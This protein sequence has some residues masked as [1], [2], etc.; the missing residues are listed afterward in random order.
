MTAATTAM[1]LL[2]QGPTAFPRAESP[3]MPSTVSTADADTRRLVTAMARGDETA[4]KQL[5]DAYSPRLF[6]LALVLG[7]GDESLA[8]EIV[9]SAFVTMAKKLRSVETA[10]H[11][12][13]WLARI[14]RQQIAKNWRQQQSNPLVSMESLPDCISTESDE[15]LENCLDSALREMEADDRQI[16]EDFYFDRLSHKQIAEQSN[17]TPKAVSSRLERAREKLRQL[18]AK[19][20]SRET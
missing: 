12:W 3:G 14:A 7:R 8:Q 1:S 17:L 6:R 11:L 5:Y 9:Q 18:V 10:D 15:T 13:N 4:F 20:L 16:I 2:D 19:K